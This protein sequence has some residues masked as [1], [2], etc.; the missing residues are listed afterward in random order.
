MTSVEP[1]IAYFSMEVALSPRMPTYSGGLGILA[2]D[3]LRSAADLGAPMVAVTPIHRGGY[4]RQAL[5]RHGNQRETPEQWRVE[6]FAVELSERVTVE[7]E[8]RP[9]SVRAWQYEIEGVEAS[10]VRV[11][12]LDTALPD[13][14]PED[15]R[16]TDS[17]YGGTPRDRLR[18][19]AV[20][21]IAGVRMLRALGHRNILSFHMNE[22]HAAL[23]S[24]ELL[25]ERAQG[26]RATREDLEAVRYRCVFTTHTPVAA[27]HD[28]FETELVRQVLSERVVQHLHDTLGDGAVLNMTEL[29]LQTA[30]KVNGVA[31][32]HA[33]VSRQ[34]FPGHVI[35]AITNGVHAATWTSEPFRRL[36]D[37]Y[38]PTWR[39]DNFDLRYAVMIPLEEIWAAHVEAKRALFD[40]IERRE[41]VRFDPT[42]LTLGFA[43]RATAYKRA[44]LIFTDLD[45]L[46]RLAAKRP[47]QIV[48]AGKAH[49]KDESGKRL[50]RAIFEAKQKLGGQ[51]S[52][53]Y[54][55]NYDMDLGASVTSG[56]D[57]WLNNPEP[58]LEASG[59]SGMKAALNGVPSLSV[60]DGWWVEGWIEG[61]TGW[62]IGPAP[63]GQQAAAD[64]SA[65]AAA[66]YDKL[67]GEVTATYYDRPERFREMMRFCIALN[68]SFFN[69]ERMVDEYLSK[70]Y[71][72]E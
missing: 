36:F 7:L 54:L 48:F 18:Q 2:G 14:A 51:I 70:A 42:V 40:V 25:A 9:V 3:T 5:D 30:G 38:F 15:R 45:R 26:R 55:Q 24:T 1:R 35:G 32:R 37:R 34:M 52:V 4:F 58:P 23:L 61:V 71:A 72:H 39:R 60:I 66:L 16:I 31:W 56:V 53:V 21:G 44:A 69:T 67:E 8:G 64:H 22:G 50:I 12:L 59:T 33:E 43:R 28:R 62:A 49:P 57:I 6:D 46:R 63:T 65:D 29:G 47:L 13:N 11:Y 68:G 17:L 27:G 20:L 10:V 19:E 41:S